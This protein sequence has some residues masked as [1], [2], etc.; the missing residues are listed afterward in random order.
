MGTVDFDNLT[1]RSP[2]GHDEGLPPTEELAAIGLK[3][4]RKDDSR[5]DSAE[6]RSRFLRVREWWRQEKEIQLANRQERMRAHDFHD[7]DQWDEEDQAAV[8]E[9]GQK[10]IVFNMVKPKIAWIAGTERRARVDYRVLPR[11]RQ[12]AQTATVKTKACKYVQDVNYAAWER[13]RAF[14]DAAV[15]GLGWIEIGRRGDMSDEPIFYS[16]EDWRNV[17]HDSRSQ[18]N[19]LSDARYVFRR[20]WVDLDVAAAMFPK[21]AGQVYASCKSS[22][23]FYSD[24]QLLD[25]AD[26]EQ[27]I[28]RAAEGNSLDGL[29]SNRRSRV[30]LVEC[31]YRMPEKVK[32]IRSQ[33][34]EL[35]TLDGAVYD[36][37]DWGMQTLVDEG[38]AG[39]YDAIKFVMRVMVFTGVGHD[40]L[41]DDPS[42]YRH[43]RFPFV[44]VWGYR[45]KRTGL[46]YGEVQNLIGPQED[47]NKRRS[48]AL[49]LL[50]ANQVVV[51]DDA[52]QDWI[53]LYTEVNRPDGVIRIKKGSTL[54]PLHENRQMAE[55]H[56]RLMDQDVRLL[57]IISGVTDENLGL[58][59]NA[60][61]GKAIM[62]RQEQGHTSLAM[63]F[64]NYR[65]AFQLSGQIELSLIE[66]Y[67]PDEKTIRLA[68]EMGQVEFVDINQ[69]DPETG[70]TLNDITSSQGDFI[71][72]EQS[73][74]ASIR[75]AMFATLGDML[76]K[77]PPEIALPLMDLWIDLSDLPGKG[78]MVE[79]IRKITGAPDPAE[80]ENSEEAMARKEQEAQAEAAKAEMLQKLAD[81]EL[82]A[83][84]VTNEKT[85]AQIQ[86]ILAKIDKMISDAKVN[87]AQAASKAVEAAARITAAATQPKRTGGAPDRGGAPGRGE[88]TVMATAPVGGR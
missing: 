17:W 25:D 58:Q 50:S 81:L 8:E 62:A 22:D 38:V 19:D 72:D 11:R 18:K 37:Q 67:W 56:V 31:W 2:P 55:G 1:Y 6:V 47:L 16:Y 39:L 43:N 71:V 74:S 32:I 29:T 61:S 34:I 53:G 10:A 79:R 63:L 33:G 77:L 7:G 87:E 86:E 60:V 13:S 15:S 20:K 69:Q 48:K 78:V 26:H 73:Y 30:E 41:Q 21:R 28:D 24:D 3:A 23:T 84:S 54:K 9:R 5:L 59:T 4:D 52:T 36:S 49:Y 70:E 27:E 14:D 40:V 35:G 66:Q 68:G 83:K 42:P 12:D 57:E 64:D 46:P 65:L 75:Q 80:D 44:P 51:D 76:A 85:R 82:E 88:R 45:Y